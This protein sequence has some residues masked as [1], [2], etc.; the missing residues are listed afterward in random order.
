MDTAARD[1]IKLLIAQGAW[2]ELRLAAQ[3]CVGGGY[4]EDCLQALVARVV[5]M[6]LQQ[7]LP[8]IDYHRFGCTMLNQ[9]TFELIFERLRTCLPFAQMEVGVSSQSLDLALYLPHSPYSQSPLQLAL[10]EFTGRLHFSVQ[11]RFVLKA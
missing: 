11:A 3:L 4:P 8:D 7:F 2:E 10:E 6:Y 5:R 1:K 9:T